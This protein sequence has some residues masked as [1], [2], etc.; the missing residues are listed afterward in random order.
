MKARIDSRRVRGPAAR[1]KN[2]A[3]REGYLFSSSCPYSSHDPVVS[4]RSCTHA[5]G[6]LA[7]P[8]QNSPPCAITC[9]SL[10][11]AAISRNIACCCIGKAQH[12]AVLRRSNHSCHC[13]SPQ[14]HSTSCLPLHVAV[15]RRDAV[16]STPSVAAA[17]H[18]HVRMIEQKGDGARIAHKEAGIYSRPSQRTRCHCH[19]SPSQDQPS[20]SAQHKR[21]AKNQQQQQEACLFSLKLC[22]LHASSAR[23]IG[24][25]WLS[26]GLCA[27]TWPPHRAAREV[28]IDPEA[29]HCGRHGAEGT[30][31]ALR[32]GI[33]RSEQRM[34]L[35]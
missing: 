26:P 22:M 35:D 6:Q 20:C 29:C 11:K 14:K 31:Q 19:T 15:P 27:G 34:S 28:G 25:E 3:C 5:R 16:R 9:G 4:S 32:L 12:I 7:L 8:K 10:C 21:S 2:S 33:Y 30:M 18:R 13:I 23:R 1:L 24:P 17:R